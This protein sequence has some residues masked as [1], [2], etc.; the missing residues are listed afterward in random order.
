M[1]QLIFL[2]VSIYHSGNIK[3][4]NKKQ[5]KSTFWTSP[6]K[7]EYKN[8][9]KK[10]KSKFIKCVLYN[11]GNLVFFYNYLYYIIIITCCV[12]GNYI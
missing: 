2:V 10:L 5:L 9:K 8:K 1:L 3:N 12:G 4:S 11:S 7:N 6:T